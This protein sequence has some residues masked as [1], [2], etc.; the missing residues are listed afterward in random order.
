MK[1]FIE[2]NIDIVSL[3][4]IVTTRSTG[5]VLEESFGLTVNHKTCSGPLGGDQE[6]GGFIT[7]DECAAAFFFIDPLSAHPRAAG[8]PAGPPRAASAVR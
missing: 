3:F 6:I 2:E 4:P 8:V 1:K 5:T 7:K